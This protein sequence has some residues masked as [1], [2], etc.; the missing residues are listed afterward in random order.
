MTNSTDWT[1]RDLDWL[2]RVEACLIELEGQCW[3]TN[4]LRK[5]LADGAV[6]VREL[7]G[8]LGMRELLSL[9]GD[10]TAEQIVKK[11]QDCRDAVMCNATGP[12]GKPWFPRA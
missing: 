11:A 8:H 9:P 2:E 1:R 6:L 4:N 5:L 10:I 7:S 12:D 3:D